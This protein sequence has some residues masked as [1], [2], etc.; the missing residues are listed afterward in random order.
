M[1]GKYGKLLRGLCDLLLWAA[2]STASLLLMKLVAP[3]RRG[4]FCGDE[5]LSYP[6]KDST[7]G[8][9][10]VIVVTLSVPSLV[11]A[12]VEL[13]KQ[14]PAKEAA[15][16]SD[17]GCATRLGQLYKQAG[18]YLFGL[19]MVTFCTVFTKLCIGRL[20]PHFFAVCQ[21]AMEDGSSC[22]DAHNLGQYI[23]SYSCRNTNA[24]SFQQHQL[25]QSFPSGHASMIMYAMWYV[26]IYLQATLSTRVSKLLKH[27]LQ[28]L[29]VMF[30]WYVA[31]SRITDYW[32]HWSDVL[33]GVLLGVLFA[34]LT[35]V[36]IADLFAFRRWTRSGYSAHTL[37][38][39]QVSPK[40]STKSQSQSQSTA[41]AAGGVPPA[42]PAYTFGTLPYTAAY[43]AQAQYA[44]T[45]HNYGYVP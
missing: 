38:R 9:I 13:F 21:P 29:F 39:G 1:S 28:F 44:Q 15:R 34:W 12:A 2:L 31:L 22:A 23:T 5:S 7:I 20:R 37:K 35:A 36:H 27:L 24:T 25:N 10:T 18:C 3:A 43:P 32:H 42:L 33:A 6:L 8:T 4:F 17:Y 14:P 16:R 26:A 30:G 41:A 11:I 19:A 45:Y 40:S